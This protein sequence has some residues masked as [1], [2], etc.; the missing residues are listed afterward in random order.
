MDLKT[1]KTI[2]LKRVLKGQKAFVSDRPFKLEISNL[3]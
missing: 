2:V 1:L 3:I